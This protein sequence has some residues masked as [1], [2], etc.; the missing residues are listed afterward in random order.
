MRSFLVTD[1]TALFASLDRSDQDHAACAAL[2][3]SGRGVLIPPTVLTETVQ[4]A[5]R[6]GLRTAADALLGLV[7]AGEIE[8]AQIDHEDWARIREPVNRY[9]DL[10]LDAV[11]ASVVALAE[12]LGEEEI[13][14]LAR[15]HFAVIRP[16][17]TRTFHLV[18]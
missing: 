11:A 15:R 14:T 3:G 7:L 8:V 6:R 13:V 12:R 18:P 4:L 9:S 17:H 5:H 1:T 16:L 10:P 2:L